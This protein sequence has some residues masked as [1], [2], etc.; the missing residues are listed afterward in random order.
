MGLP[1]FCDKRSVVVSFSSWT[2]LELLTPWLGLFLSISFRQKV[3]VHD[4]GHGLQ[5]FCLRRHQVCSSMGH[6]V[7]QFLTRVVSTRVTPYFQCCL[8]LLWMPLTWW[9]QKQRTD[10]RLFT[11][12][13]LDLVTQRLSL[14]ANDIILFFWDS[15]ADVQIVVSLQEIFKEASGL[16][17]N[18]L[19]TSVY[20]IHYDVFFA[21]IHCNFLNCQLAHFHVIYLSLPLNCKRPSKEDLQ[22]LLDIIRS[23]LASWQINMLTQCGR[24]SMWPCRSCAA[25]PDMDCNITSAISW[26]PALDV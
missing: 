5:W 11:P 23:W 8:T 18:L 16:S 4:G 3:S 17:W 25:C 26:S 13:P 9:S 12:F 14:Y 15:P 10:C 21:M 1:K 2:L 24:V 7:P 19:K 6:R 20:P 22:R